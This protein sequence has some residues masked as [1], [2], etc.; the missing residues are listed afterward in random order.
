MKLYIVKFCA[1]EYDDLGYDPPYPI[2]YSLDKNKARNYFE[3]L[4][5]QEIDHF[6]NYIKSHPELQNN[7]EKKKKKNSIDEFEYNFGKWFYKYIYCED[8]MNVDL[9][10]H[11]NN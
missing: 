6:N 3:Q 8:E 2:F 9:R 7:E 1:N 10:Y 5:E 4:R 11:I